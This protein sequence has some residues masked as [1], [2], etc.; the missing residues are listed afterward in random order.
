MCY[1]Q[2]LKYK[3]LVKGKK[4]RAAE[5]CSSSCSDLSS[6]DEESIRSDGKPK[7][8][9]EDKKVGTAAAAAPSVPYFT[10]ESQ[11]KVTATSCLHAELTK[12]LDVLISA[13]CVQA[14]SRAFGAGGVHSQCSL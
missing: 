10:V 8:K 11:D 14:K 13:E 12:K 4:E 3:I 7:A 1:F 2:D 9:K 6:S 5:G